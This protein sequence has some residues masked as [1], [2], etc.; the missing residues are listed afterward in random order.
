MPTDEQ[1]K[2]A[3]RLLLGLYV[4]IPLVYILERIL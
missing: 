2:R 1:F 4:F 3:E